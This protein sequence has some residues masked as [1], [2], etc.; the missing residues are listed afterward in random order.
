MYGFSKDKFQSGKV[1]L[2]NGSM[3][4]WI[5]CGDEMKK[6]G[7]RIKY[8]KFPEKDLDLMSKDNLLKKR[9]QRF[10]KFNKGTIKL[11]DPSNLKFKRQANIWIKVC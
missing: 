5:I 7:Y 11:N 10:L 4:Q 1:I 8:K 6:M 3:N 9:L 2:K